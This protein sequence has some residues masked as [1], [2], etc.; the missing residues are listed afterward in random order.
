[1]TAAKIKIACLG[2]LLVF[3]A[4]PSPAAEDW[5]QLKFDAR[6]SG[7]VPQRSVS[8]PLGLVGA[9]PLGDAVF[10]APVVG[11]GKV[12]AIDG[13]GTVWAIDAASLRVVWRFETAGGKANCNNV[14][15]PAIAGR[16]LHVG[17]MAGKYYVLDA[18]SGAL[19]KT[20]D[21]GEP[22]FSAP[23]VGR[24]RVY[25]ATLGSRVH[26]LKL[27]GT[28]VWVWD[29]VKERLGFTGDRW[30]GLDWHKQKGQATWRE[31]F[32][33]TR[34]VALDGRTVVLPAGGSLVWLEDA[35]EKAEYR[36]VFLGNRESP[37]T[38]GLSLGPNGAV[39]RQWTQRDNGGR[40]EVLHLASG[41]VQAGFV[42]GTETSY[43]GP[44]LMSFSSVS[45]RGQ[46]VYRCRPEQGFGLCLHSAGQTKPLGGYPSISSPIL[47]RDAA[48][49]GGLDG[50]LYVVP[51]SGGPGWSFKTPFGK[52][53]SAPAAVCDGRIYFGGEDGYLYVLGPGGDAPLPSKDLGLEQVRS[54]LAGEKTD[55]PFDWFTS[56]GNW[57]NTNATRQGLKL[58]LA[59]HWIRR[60][61]GTV[62]HFSV[63]GGGRM[64]THTAEGQVF[65]VEQETGRLL[66]RRYFPGVH[67]SYTSPLYYQGRLLVPQAGLAECWLRSLDAAT[68]KLLWQAPFTGSPS[69]NRQSPP[70]VWKNLAIYQF[71]SGRYT[72]EGWLFEHQST[73]GFPA[74]QKPL[75]R[76]WDLQTGKEAWTRDFSQYGAGG[77]D[78]GMC[79]MDGTLYYS[80]YFGNKPTP[81]ITAALDPAGGEV[82][83]LS[84][85]HSVHAGCTVSGKDGRLYLGG[86]NPVE[87][88][89]NVVWCLDAR[90][91]SLVW[92][93]DPVLGAIHVVTV[94]DK[95]LFAHAQY[96]NAYLLDRKTGKIL[97]TL[98]K[99]Y[100]CTRFTYCEPYLVGPNFDIF[101][102]SGPPALISSGPQ[103]D[104]LMCVGAFCSNG[105]LF[106]T[107]NGSGLQASMTSP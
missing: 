69:W 104:V 48:V 68:G 83:W 86:Y 31:Q 105:R 94:A 59:L 70:I 9:V 28:P 98:A 49:L 51:L 39:Y 34:D 21:C 90:D 35:G 15:S 16:Y 25:F 18:A 106:L 53:I 26:A 2:I 77:D 57:A 62:K 3:A 58:P 88:D 84:T 40:V 54:P 23:V 46:D 74:D 85:K 71:S 32:C 44:G 63:C 78:A 14:S 60:Y 56:F 92:K 102:L 36:G 41:K 96:R 79:L 22:I 76:A 45:I 12:F 75:V 72:P 103:L 19:V 52:A 101:D 47:L 24:D 8:V 80:C 43:N 5:L 97:S 11:D 6:H 64:Y 30:S 91:G 61:E 1:M 13:S 81:G 50:A 67:V 38:L 66:W 82:K 33:C 95:F 99:G 29:F 100:R 55:A 10:T 89:K 73:F 17:T 87:G 37:A 107:T 7:D 20:L 27:D 42:R 93:S 65:A 4:G